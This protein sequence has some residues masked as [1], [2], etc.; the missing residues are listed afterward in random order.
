MRLLAIIHK[1]YKNELPRR[2]C[3]VKMTQVIRSKIL[4]ALRED[5]E[6]M[7]R[8]REAQTQEDVRKVLSD[9]CQKK[10]Y[11]VEQRTPS[12]KGSSR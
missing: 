11:S 7:D 9:F 1:T 12:K 8:L 3:N 4:R 2:L 6:W 10:G 5:P